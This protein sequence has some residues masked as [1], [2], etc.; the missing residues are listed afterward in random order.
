MSVLAGM[1]MQER[2]S[3]EQFPWKMRVCI[4][5]GETIMGLVGNKRKTYTAVGDAVNLASRI[6]AICTPGIVTVDE[7]TYQDI[8]QFVDTR[9][10]TVLPLH[11]FEDPQFVKAIGEYTFMLDQNPDD[12]N[13]IKKLGLFLLQANYPD[14][15]HDYLHRALEL[16]PKN[17]SVKLAYAE[18]TMKIDQM[19]SFSVKGKKNRL[20]L[21]EIIRIKDP[22]KIR[23]KIPQKVY[24]A[25]IDRVRDT[26]EYPEDLI[27]PVESLDGSI[28]HARVVGFLSYALADLMKL[29]DREKRD[30][31]RAAYLADIGK[32]IVPHHLLNR[33]GGLSQTEF[34]ETTKHCREGVQML[35]KL[36]YRDESLFEMIVSH[37]ES[38]N[39]SGYPMHLKGSDIPLGA[40]IISVADCYDALTSWRPYRERWDYRAAYAEMGKETRNGKFDSAVFNCLG[41]LLGIEPILV[42]DDLI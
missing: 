2:L 38:F 33:N 37:H 32:A 1:K 28:G 30:I 23:D 36:G 25:Y 10:K 35:K 31:L 40:R 7:T 3:K 26:S 19:D 8:C 12:L 17:D 29:S 21:F 22:L 9:K 42:L 13:L 24:D 18:V 14:L 4:A 20:H 6:Q 39:G 15:A 11:E 27:L 34:Q 16:D 41:K 5:T